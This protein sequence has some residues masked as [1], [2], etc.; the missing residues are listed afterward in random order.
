MIIKKQGLLY[1]YTSVGMGVYVYTSS[2]IVYFDLEPV[3]VEIG[4]KCC[5]Y[6]KLISP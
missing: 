3:V 6:P 2:E 4:L 5:G 1:P